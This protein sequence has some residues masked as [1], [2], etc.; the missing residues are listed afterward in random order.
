MM[1]MLK[2][3]YERDIR[4]DESTESEDIKYGL[5]IGLAG[6]AWAWAMAVTGKK[7]TRTRL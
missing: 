5:F 7:S 1:K 6:R 3:V 4:W 2:I